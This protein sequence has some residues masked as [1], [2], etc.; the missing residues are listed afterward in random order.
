[1][2]S[3]VSK[4]PAPHKHIQLLFNHNFVDV[5]PHN[6][7]RLVRR[8]RKHIRTPRRRVSASLLQVGGR[9]FP[10]VF[11][12]QHAHHVFQHFLCRHFSLVRQTFLATLQRL[13]IVVRPSPIQPRQLLHASQPVRAHHPKHRK[14]P[15][16]ATRP[17]KH[18]PIKDPIRRNRKRVSLHI[19]NRIRNRN[20]ARS[21]TRSRRQD[22]MKCE[23]RQ[24]PLAAKPQK[25]GP[26]IFMPLLSKC[27]CSAGLQTGR[28][29]VR[30]AVRR[31]RS[32]G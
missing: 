22:V 28:V 31:C 19:Q 21:L 13:P 9:L 24:Q 27:L 5:I 14:R 1:M 7:A 16:I 11:H 3:D 23:D 30:L 10:H 25:N 6:G 8:H 2:L 20:D 29:V 15:V 26:M 32:P 18:R 12:L 4:I 17:R